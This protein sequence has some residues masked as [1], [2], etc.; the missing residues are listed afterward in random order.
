[1]SMILFVALSAV[2]ISRGYAECYE[3]AI[4]MYFFLFLRRGGGY[5]KADKHKEKATVK[6][7]Q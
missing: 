1:M 3:D 5:R 4:E 2:F 6:E 7:M